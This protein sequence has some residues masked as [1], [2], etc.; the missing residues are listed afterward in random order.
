MSK[1]LS[2]CL[3][4]AFLGLATIASAGTTRP[5]ATPPA[6]IAN[7][8][9]ADPTANANDFLDGEVAQAVLEA[10][11]L[12]PDTANVVLS[13]SAG[14]FQK[15]VT[16]V[17]GTTTNLAAMAPGEKKDN[18]T[19]LVNLFSGKSGTF[20]TSDVFIASGLRQTTSLATSTSTVN[21]LNNSIGGRMSTVLAER[22]SQEIK[23]GSDSAMASSAMNANFANR[24]WIGGFGV[25]QDMGQKDGYEGYK[26]SSHGFITGYDRAF[27]PLTLGAAFSYNRG[28]LNVDNAIDDNKIDN[29]SLSAYATYS[30][31]SGFFATMNGGW[32]RGDN[33]M[34]DYVAASDG[35]RYGDYDTDSYWLGGSMGYDFRIN[36]LTITPSIGLQ[37]QKSRSDA[38]TTTG[39]IHQN[40]GKMNSKALTMPIDLAIAYTARISPDAS[41][42]FS[43]NGG[44]G[45]DFEN[46]GAT[47]SMNYVGYNES[48]QIQ[49]VKPG[50]SS[51]NTGVGLKY[52]YKR[53]DFSAN[54]RYD[55]K[56]DF[57][58]HTVIGAFGIS[59]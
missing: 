35:W 9:I 54:Y 50:R 29:Y 10:I 20:A 53:F 23:F 41:F 2:T 47:G 56:K 11:S 5:A 7:N 37:Y 26:Y 19:F 21:Q 32:N 38:Y 44:Y 34:A 57:D 28:D 51:W 33:K 24:F 52:Q 6:V 36:C 25:W 1:R 8:F 40:F 3:V 22:R 39:I 42:T 12:A 30:H 16:E 55:G 17:L 27:G 59:F 14:T 45:Y 58:S 13:S 49:G 43:A 31:T 48:I 18:A 15:A 4:L 46:K